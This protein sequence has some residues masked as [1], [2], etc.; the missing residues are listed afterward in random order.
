[1]SLGEVVN[2]IAGGWMMYQFIIYERSAGRLTEGKVVIW[3]VNIILQLIKAE[4]GL[5][6]LKMALSLFPKS[7]EHRIKNLK[8]FKNSLCLKTI[9][10]DK[11]A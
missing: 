8:F 5:R 9:H 10:R 2:G 4:V 1:L 6:F 11:I 7:S 3:K